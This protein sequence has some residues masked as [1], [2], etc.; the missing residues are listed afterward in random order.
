MRNKELGYDRREKIRF[1]VKIR[2]GFF[3]L[4][5]ERGIV[6]VFGSVFFWFF[7][8]VFKCV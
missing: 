4:I 7:G 5:E 6:F 1:R 3:S 8:W 2:C